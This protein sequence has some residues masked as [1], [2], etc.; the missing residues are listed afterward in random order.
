MRCCERGGEFSKFKNAMV[1]SWI[2]VSLTRVRVTLDLT[3]GQLTPNNNTPLLAQAL[4][5]SS[6]SKRPRS[7]DVTFTLRRRDSSVSLTPAQRR[8]GVRAASPRR[9]VANCQMPAAPPLLTP[10]R[11]CA[12]VNETLASERRHWR[13]G[14]AT[15]EQLPSSSGRLRATRVAARGGGRAGFPAASS[16]GPALDV[17]GSAAD[18]VGYVQAASPQPS[19]FPAIAV[20]RA[21]LNY[22][23]LVS[24]CA[25][26]ARSR[27]ARRRRD[28]RAASSSTADAISSRRHSKILARRVPKYERDE[29][30]GRQSTRCSAA[31]NG[32]LKLRPRSITASLR[33]HQSSLLVGARQRRRR[34]RDLNSSRRLLVATKAHVF[35]GLF[36][37]VVS[38]AISCP[39]AAGASY[40]KWDINSIVASG[41]ASRNAVDRARRRHVSST[42]PAPAS[43]PAQARGAATSVRHARTTNPIN[44]PPTTPKPP[45]ERRPFLVPSFIKEQFA[46]RFAHAVTRRR[47]ASEPRPRR[48]AA[49]QAAGDNKRPRRTPPR[50]VRRSALVAGRRARF[51]FF[52]SCREFVRCRRAARA[53]CRARAART[54]R[55]PHTPHRRRR[56]RDYVVKTLARKLIMKSKGAGPAAA[57]CALP[58]ANRTRIGSAR[59]DQ[60]IG[61][62]CRCPLGSGPS[63]PAGT[64]DAVGARA[65]PRPSSPGTRHPATPPPRNAARL[66]SFSRLLLDCVLRVLTDFL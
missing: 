20:S 43:A 51:A 13:R 60:P 44:H 34:R 57:R 30:A 63:E 33:R 15:D 24:E 21:P 59:T 62:H 6:S 18:S 23:P 48:A 35:G 47:A 11:C 32:F 36:E 40:I 26:H 22:T 42:G 46:L 53:A 25:G 56:D 17:Y 29:R 9:Q 49:A 16:P 52:R 14:G 12:G 66:V 28:P 10:R 1:Q 31:G 54:P 38:G 19:G 39:S 2:C 27:A 8:R 58:S 41:V 3:N 5:A 45:L 65:S 4:S 55:E 61:S 37:L 7:A 50:S 64:Q